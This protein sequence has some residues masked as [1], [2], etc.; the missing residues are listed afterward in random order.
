M[1]REKKRNAVAETRSRNKRVARAGARA[2]GGIE[3]RERVR[4]R[5]VEKEGRRDTGEET[6]T[7]CAWFSTTRLQGKGRRGCSRSLP[8]PHPRLCFSPFFLSVSLSSSV[9]SVSNLLA[10]SPSAPSFYPRPEKTNFSC[11]VQRLHRSLRVH[12]HHHHHPPIVPTTIVTPPS[13]YEHT[14]W[15][16]STVF[17]YHHRRGTDS[18]P[19]PNNHHRLRQRQQPPAPAPPSP[20][21]LLPS[22]RV[23]PPAAASGGSIRVQSLSSTAVRAVAL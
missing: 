9:T 2:P 13:L 11:P 6:Q 12:H 7:R 10:T 21:G 19:T 5:E 1:K 17:C 8:I 15:S 3:R 14:G 22:L 23:A 20:S 18:P 4:K 16:T